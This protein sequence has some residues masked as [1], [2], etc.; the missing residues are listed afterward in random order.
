MVMGGKI[1]RR[2]WLVWKKKKVKMVKEEED[3]VGVLVGEGGGVVGPE[4][5]HLSFDND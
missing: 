1:G 4:A 5:L 3:G 2:R